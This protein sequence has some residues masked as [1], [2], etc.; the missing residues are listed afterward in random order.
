MERGIVI[1]CLCCKVKWMG[2]IL[3]RS[4]KCLKDEWQFPGLSGTCRYSKAEGSGIFRMGIVF[5]A[6]QYS[7]NIVKNL[8]FD[9]NA[10][11]LTD[12][13]LPFLDLTE[14]NQFQFSHVVVDSRFLTII[15]RTSLF[16][17][18]L[19]LYHRARPIVE[20]TPTM[21]QNSI[22][23]DKASTSININTALF[24]ICFGSFF[25]NIFT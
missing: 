12:F 16:W 8:K 18:S 22:S 25:Y 7:W 2:D 10:M 5:F 17:H 14:G 6:S 13:T 21:R 9:T 15:L 20:M 3:I 19:G 23:L 4:M 11:Y 1:S 24:L